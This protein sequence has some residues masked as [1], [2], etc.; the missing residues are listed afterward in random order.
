MLYWFFCGAFLFDYFA[1]RNSKN[2][3][4]NFLKMQFRR[5][6]PLKKNY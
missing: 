6:F 5:I 2:N 3:I 1:L 4:D